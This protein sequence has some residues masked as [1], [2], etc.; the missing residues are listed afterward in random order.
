[1]E[2]ANQSVQEEL[3]GQIDKY[4][5]HSSVVNVL[6]VSLKGVIEKEKPNMGVNIDDFAIIKTNLCEVPL[7][8]ITKDN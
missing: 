8:L 5:A 2:K 3:Q 7:H 1:M 6:A 4:A